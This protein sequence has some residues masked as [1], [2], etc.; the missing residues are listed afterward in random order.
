MKFNLDDVQLKT[1]GVQLRELILE[2]YDSIK[3]FADAIDLYESSI[4]QYLS[5]KNLGSNT[6]KIRMTRVFGKD[7]HSLYKTNEEQ[8]RYYV[9]TI[10][11]YIND[12]NK[13][14]DLQI[15]ERLKKYSLEMEC[16]E[17]YA[18]ICRCYAYYYFNQGMKDRAFAYMEVAVNT[19]RDRTYV[20]RFGLYLSD[21]IYMQAQDISRTILKKYIEELKTVLKDVVGPDTRGHIYYKLGLAYISM[22][23]YDVARKHMKKVLEYHK[24]EEWLSTAYLRLGDIERLSENDEKAYA[25]YKNAEKILPE[26]SEAMLHVYDELAFHYLKQG[27]FI[28]AE[29]YIDRVFNQNEWFISS[30]SHNFLRTYA[31]IKVGLDK[32]SEFVFTYKTLMEEIEQ[33]FIHT[34]HHL[35]L[36]SKMMSWDVWAEKTMRSILMASIDYINKNRVDNAY[37]KMIQQIIGSV[38]VKNHKTLLN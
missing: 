9:E 7:F 13:K 26:T 30:S 35:D 12:Y 3:A 38:I 18:V 33:G 29:M 25:E 34:R 31:Q 28:Q 14:S 10:S 6:F 15:F 32:E 4:T 8:L 2:N 1:P 17:D 23:E 21:L 16:L 24:K 5:S 20:D 22:G 11:F 37:E 27:D 36:I 19:M